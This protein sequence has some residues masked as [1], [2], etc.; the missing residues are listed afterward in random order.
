MPGRL[1]KKYIWGTSI[2]L[3]AL[4]IVLLVSINV[5]FQ[6]R[7]EAQAE[8]LLQFILE[9][10]DNPEQAKDAL[11]T[12]GAHILA[13]YTG[14]TPYAALVTS[15]WF[16]AEVR[17]DITGEIDLAHAVE[18]TPNEARALVEAA[19]I[20]SRASS[21]RVGQY[22]FL[23]E[24]TGDAAY[25]YA[26]LDISELMLQSVQLG[27][28]S[29]AAGFMAIAAVL[30]YIWLSAAGV[31]APL[32]RKV[33]EG[34]RLM[35]SAADRITDDAAAE[36][37][38]GVRDGLTAGSEVLE[39]APGRKRAIPLSDVLSHACAGVLEAVEDKG[40]LLEADIQADV[41]VKAY[42]GELSAL[43]ELMLDTAARTMRPGGTVSVD[44]LSDGRQVGLIVRSTCAPWSAGDEPEA[45]ALAA[46]RLIARNNNGNTTFEA[47]DP[48]TLCYTV[49]FRAAAQQR[50]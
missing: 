1:Q 32:V 48:D 11:D 40:G 12:R 47:I 50:R 24:Q 34:A 31:I 23:K 45:D 42:P 13:Q 20:E 17:D 8:Q 30:V 41:S 36:Q 15:S 44:L 25:R 35:Q 22:R 14:K 6:S 38:A 10:G 33:D 26:L 49:R 7:C 37:L 28:S 4:V 19:R 43:C 9:Y 18:I 39:G 27:T 16:T 21:G 2:A 3:C 29:V 5:G 46:V